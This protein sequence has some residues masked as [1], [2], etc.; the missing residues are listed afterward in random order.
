MGGRDI[1]AREDMSISRG[2]TER[3]S[4]AREHGIALPVLTPISGHRDPS[5]R[6][7][8]LHLHRHHVPAPAHVREQHKVEIR[9]PI[10]GEAHA[11]FLLARH[12]PVSHRHDPALVPRD[13]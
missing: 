6:P 11:A 5:P 9:V 3:Q 4:L 8:P 13:L 7:A 1:Q 12:A 10:D 2:D